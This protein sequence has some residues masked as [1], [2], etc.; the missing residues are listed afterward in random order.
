LDHTSLRHHFERAL[1][2][3]AILLAL[4]D[5]QLTDRDPSYG[6]RAR[7]RVQLSDHLHLFSFHARKAIELA[8]LVS[9]ASNLPLAKPGDVPPKEIVE[10]MGVVTHTTKDLWFVLNRIIHSKELGIGEAETK[11]VVGPDWAPSPRLTSYWT[12]SVFSVRSDR[13]G[14]D[15]QHWVEPKHLIAAFLQLEPAFKEVLDIG[16]PP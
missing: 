14:V 4:S 1:D 12:P 11:T 2:H 10:E 5:H 15:E 7:Q 9:A 16:P 6:L 8:D 13:D 3:A